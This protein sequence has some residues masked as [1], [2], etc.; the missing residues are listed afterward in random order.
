MLECGCSGPLSVVWGKSCR[1]W[2]GGVGDVTEPQTAPSPCL[3]A[4]SAHQQC[5]TVHL[6]DFCVM[7]WFAFAKVAVVVSQQASSIG[8]TVL[9]RLRSICRR[10]TADT[11]R[12]HWWMK[13]GKREVFVG[14]LQGLGRKRLL[15]CISAGIMRKSYG[16]CMAR[17]GWLG[18]ID[19]GMRMGL[20]SAHQ[21]VI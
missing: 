12:R 16:G 10:S 6:T 17:W 15:S 13:C 5:P 19:G 3:A 21:T 2:D 1:R 8:A 7:H 18:D 9:E 4:A 20:T 11:S 14:G